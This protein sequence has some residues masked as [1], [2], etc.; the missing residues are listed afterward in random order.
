MA[1]VTRVGDAASQWKRKGR[2]TRLGPASFHGPLVHLFGLQFSIAQALPLGESAPLQGT[3]VLTGT[4]VA[5]RWN[6]T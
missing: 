1:T 5:T 2:R 6:C 4:G 3:P